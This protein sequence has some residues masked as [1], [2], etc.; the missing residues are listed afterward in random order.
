MTV[1]GSQQFQTIDGFGTNL[2][3]EAWNKGAVV[4]SLDKLL[5]H[6]YKLYRVIVEP[7]QGWE[8][9]NP[10]TGQFSDS[11]PN[12]AYY[13]NLYGTSTKFTNLWN[14][15][16]YLN[17]HGATVWVNLQ[18]DAPAWMTDNGGAPATIGPD[19]EADW[20]TMVSTMVDYAVNTA[21]VRINAVGPMNEPDVADYVQGPQVGPTQY[22]RMLD[23]LEKQLQGYGL[24]NIPLVGPDTAS[25]GV[26]V[27]SYVPAMLADP[28][29]MPHVLQFGFH[30]YGGSV[31]DSAITNNSTYPGT[32][33]FVRRVRRTVLQRRP[34]PAG[35]T[36]RA[37]GPGRFEL[38]EPD[39]D[40][41]CRRKW[42]HHLGR[43]GQLLRILRAVERPWA[44]QLRLDGP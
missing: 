11:N 13:N 41:Q 42:G 40:R 22:V 5:Q 38:P 31:S 36:R 30:T 15:V 18:S 19:H 21:H 34:W 39:F 7:V 27:N 35:D 23:T 10:N 9:T 12:W 6:G 8:D 43:R 29:L 37:M 33:H 26:G 24:G 32:A 17:H 4:P 2:S 14:T 16:S 25:A 44:D 20:A 3:S 1:D 28:F